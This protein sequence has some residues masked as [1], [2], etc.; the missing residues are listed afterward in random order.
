MLLSRA[1]KIC[2]YFVFYYRG[3]TPTKF[4]HILTKSKRKELPHKI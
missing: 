4:G 2:V 1:Q 3:A